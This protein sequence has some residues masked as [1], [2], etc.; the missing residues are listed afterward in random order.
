[1]ILPFR[2]LGYDC[3]FVNV[4]FSTRDNRENA[5][6]MFLRSALKR[7][8]IKWGSETIKIEWTEENGSKWGDAVGN[9]GAI[10]FLC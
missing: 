4:H 8:Q 6:N 9:A 7:E 1:M 2:Y 3:C 10:F 5:F